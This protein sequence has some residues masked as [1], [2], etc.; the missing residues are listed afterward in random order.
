MA[1]PKPFKYKIKNPQKYS[2]DI[3]NCISRS[4]WETRF[5]TFCDHNP[6]ILAWGSE[7]AG[8]II[9]YIHPITGNYHRYFPD[10]IIRVLTKEN[11]VKTMLIEVKPRK[12]TIQ[13]KEPLKK[14]RKAMSNFK[15]AQETFAI[16][17]AKWNAARLWCK[18]Q[19]IDFQI[20]TEYELGIKKR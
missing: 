19:N 18:S 2:G 7:H 13:P 6:N 16:N 15:K 9:R 5:M 8:S 14:T 17:T 12:E 3:N 10:F 11:I 4:S 20:F 1:R